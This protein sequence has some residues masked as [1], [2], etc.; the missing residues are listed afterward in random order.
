MVIGTSRS[1]AFAFLETWLRQGRFQSA[2]ASL[3]ENSQLK[4][5]Y[6]DEF[7]VLRSELCLEVGKISEATSLVEAA[8]RRGRL[9]ADQVARAKVVLS[10]ASFYKGDG[11]SCLSI[12]A[13][14]QKAADI[15]QSSLL[16]AHVALL[17]FAVALNIQPIENV[18]TRL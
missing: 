18:L 9:V 17:S 14:A 1:D 16:R 5:K 8:L 3:D 11:I 12:L 6:I 13:E 4:S 15:G 10:T 7:S 2:L